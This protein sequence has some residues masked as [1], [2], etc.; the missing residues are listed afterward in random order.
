MSADAEYLIGAGGDFEIGHETWSCGGRPVTAKC[1]VGPAR[2]TTLQ[3]YCHKQFEKY[4]ASTFLV[5]NEERYTYAEC[6][7]SIKSLAT[8]LVRD[9]GVES[10]DRVTVCM[11]N[12]P[13]W[14]IAFLAASCAGAVVVP[15]N[16]LW[17]GEELAYGLQDSGTKV[18]ICDEER[19]RRAAPSIEGLGL[20]AILV[21]REQPTPDGATRRLAAKLGVPTYA[22]VVGRY[23]G[24]SLPAVPLADHDAAALIM[25]TSGTTSSPKGVV[26]TQRGI[27]NQLAMSLLAT[28]MDEESGAA[29]LRTEQPCIV[30][31]VPLFHVTASHHVFL[32]SLCSGR[33]MAMMYKWDPLKALQLIERERPQGWTGVPTM[34]QDLMNHEDFDKYDTS[35]LLGIG[36]GA[37]PRPPRRWAAWARSSSTRLRTRA[38]V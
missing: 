15:L 7:A 21:E 30:L 4:A 29:A 12:Y 37:P 14:C 34:V 24:A 25:Y 36:G 35:S 22:D 19:L 33:K 2:P 18:I 5:Y 28:R 32:Q 9:F 17:K 26:Q 38:T 10:G 11:R 16:S 20:R 27:C 8:A 31:P 13:E 1:F 6:W 23:A 3:G